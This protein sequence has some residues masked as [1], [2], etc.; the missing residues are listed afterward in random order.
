MSAF[1]GQRQRI[2]SRS[3]NMA[4]CGPCLRNH[5][6][7]SVQACYGAK[8][9]VEAHNAC[10]GDPSPGCNRQRGQVYRVGGLSCRVSLTFVKE[11]LAIMR[12]KDQ[13]AKLSKQPQRINLWSRK[14]TDTLRR[15]RYFPFV[16]D[17]TDFYGKEGHQVG[18]LFQAQCQVFEIRCGFTKRHST[19][20]T[21]A[22]LVHPGL[23][24]LRTS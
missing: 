22:K 24:L 20:Y 1:Q 15:P 12:V 3:D 10:A 19:V 16:L 7:H 5:K 18:P 17:A 8:G 4:I 11:N 9:V 13:H 23:C 2:A 14:L 6:Q 21:L